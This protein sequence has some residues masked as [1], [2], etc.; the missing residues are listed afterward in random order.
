MPTLYLDHNSENFKDYRT[1]EIAKEK[2]MLKKS[3]NDNKNFLI[4]KCKFCE[5]SYTEGKM[6]RKHLSEAHKVYGPEISND[7]N[8][9][10][11]G[12]HDS[13]LYSKELISNQSV[14]IIPKRLPTIIKVNVANPES[15]DEVVSKIFAG[16]LEMNEQNLDFKEE[17]L[18]QE[19]PIDV[20]PWNIGSLFD[21]QYFNC[22][23]CD[24]KNGSKQTF[25]CHAFATHPESVE[26]LKN[27]SDGSLNNIL[28]PWNS[29]SFSQTI[30]TFDSKTSKV[31]KNDD[32]EDNFDDDPLKTNSEIENLDTFNEINAKKFK[33]FEVVDNLYDSMMG[34]NENNVTTKAKDKRHVCKHCKKTFKEKFNL[35]V[36]VDNVHKGLKK[37]KCDICG[38]QFTQKSSLKLHVKGVHEKKRNHKC[39]QCDKAYFQAAGLSN[40]KSIHSEKK[41]KCYMCQKLYFRHDVLKSHIKNSHK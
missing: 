24:F 13:I 6:F 27:I 30:H 10:A 1:A 2:Q 39:D 3:N 41:F 20:N 40:H 7:N 11:G 23:S 14:K 26:Y 36:H 5:R 18:E 32:G 25:V 22:P 34:K 15:V 8:A 16:S 31:E 21:L 37:F 35:K 4:F 12:G 28:C 33:F 19:N 29:N 9:K 17:I 38:K